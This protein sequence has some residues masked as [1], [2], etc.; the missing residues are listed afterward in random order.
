MPDPL[1]PV[2]AVIA[3]LL[4]SYGIGMWENVVS[5]GL[6]LQ[7]QAVDLLSTVSEIDENPVGNLQRDPPDAA[8][9]GGVPRPNEPTRNDALRQRFS[10][11]EAARAMVL[12]DPVPP[13]NSITGLIRRG[14]L[15]QAR[16]HLTDLQT[17]F[18]SHQTFLYSAADLADDA[19]GSS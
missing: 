10:L 3:G 11:I 18:A 17:L 4:L 2:A 12:Q 5:S 14:D 15:S 1:W 19:T 8:T 6:Q 9:A 7:Q 16:S 13:D